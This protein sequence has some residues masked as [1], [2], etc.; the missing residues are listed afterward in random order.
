MSEEKK[1]RTLTGKV[2]SDKMDKSIVVMIERRERHPIY[3]KYVKRSTKLH[4]H[5]AQN[6]AKAGDTVSIEESRPLSKKKAWTLVEVV[7]QAKG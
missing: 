2:V 3:G 5:D 6:Q 1:V 4:A 7:E